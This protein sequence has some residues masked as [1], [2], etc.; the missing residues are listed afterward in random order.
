MPAIL[1]PDAVVH[2]WRHVNGDALSLV[3]IQTDDDAEDVDGTP[4]P[5][6][7]GTLCYGGIKAFADDEEFLVEFGPVAAALDGTAVVTPGQASPPIAAMLS[8]SA[9]KDV[10]LDLDL[11]PGFKGVFAFKFWPGGREEDAYTFSMGPFKIVL[12]AG[13]GL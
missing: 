10:L 6:E 1:T 8:V 2:E 3:Y 5:F 9:D 11:A 13:S 7:A 12:S 4:E